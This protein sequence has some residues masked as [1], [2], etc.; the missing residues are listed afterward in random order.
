MTSVLLVSPVPTNR[1]PR[2]RPDLHLCC[3]SGGAPPGWAAG[4]PY[5]GRQF[6]SLFLP[7]LSGVH[8]AEN[9]QLRVGQAD[10]AQHQAAQETPEIFT[11][12]SNAPPQSVNGRRN[13][14]SALSRTI[15]SRSLERAAVS[16][17]FSPVS[18]S[19]RPT[20]RKSLLSR[21]LP[22]IQSFLSAALFARFLKR[23]LLIPAG[24]GSIPMR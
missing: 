21:R 5:D 7:S 2:Q 3:R 24:R 16:R 13:F 9:F 15:W 6:S 19:G 18:F 12:I 17:P 10:S 22:I 4:S 8:H 23:K 14:P 11:P 20:A 1:C